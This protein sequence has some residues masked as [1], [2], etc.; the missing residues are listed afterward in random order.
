MR[1]KSKY[2]LLNNKEWLN[3]KYIAEGLSTVEIAKIVGVKAANSV[4]QALIRH[5]IKVRNLS[6]GLTFGRKSDQFELNKRSI[7]VLYGCLLGDGYLRC[8]NKRSSISNPYFAKINK[9]RDH[10]TLVATELFNSVSLAKVKESVNVCR[11]KS[12]IYYSMR[13][14]SH[15][16]LKPIYDKWYPLCSGFKK[17]VPRGL[18]LTPLMIMH[19][20]MDDGCSYRRKREYKKENPK[21]VWKNGNA[22]KNENQIIISFSSESF[23]KE[24]QE[25]LAG[26]MKN[27]FGLDAKVCPCQF[28]TGWRIFIPQSQ[29]QKFFEII[30]PCPVPSLAYKWK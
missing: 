6:D 19:W 2:D 4:R 3:Q 28:G 25:F 9:F 20:F 30:G 1:T 22:K 18:K 17:V 15:V 5:G 29:A 27:T 11:G 14:L 12:L 10:I 26:Q 24:D 23:S 8:H 21:Y 16:E 13:S 7:Q